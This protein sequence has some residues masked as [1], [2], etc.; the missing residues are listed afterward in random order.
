MVLLSNHWGC[1]DLFH[2]LVSLMTLRSSR[3]GAEYA[4]YM[5]TAPVRKEGSVYSPV[6]V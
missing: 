2:C 3:L 5:S 6:N 4:T 1:L